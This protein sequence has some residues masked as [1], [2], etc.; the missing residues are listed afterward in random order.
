M[1]TAYDVHS[2]KTWPQNGQLVVVRWYN[3]YMQTPS[4]Q[5]ATFVNTN[6]PYWAIA[7]RQRLTLPADTYIT[8]WVL[9]DTKEVEAP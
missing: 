6:G 5:V 2:P 9:L 4:Y 1:W 8:H 7:E 3:P